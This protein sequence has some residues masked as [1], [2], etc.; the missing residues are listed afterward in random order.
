MLRANHCILTGD[1]ELP[2]PGGQ[3]SSSPTRSSSSATRTGW[4]P[5][6]TSCSRTPKAASAAETRRVRHREAAPARSTTATRHHV[7]R[8]SRP[9]A[10]QFGNQD[11]DVYFY[12]ETIEKL[13][14]AEVPHHARRLH[15]LRAAD[16]ALGGDQRHRGLNLNDYAIATNTVLR[17]KGVP[18]FYLPVIYYPIRGRPARHRVPAADLRHVDAA[19]SGDQQRVLLGDR[20]QPG[21]HVLPRL[22]HAHRAGCGRRIPLRRG[23]AVVRQRPV[24]P[25]RPERD[26]V[27]RQRTDVHAAGATRASRSQAT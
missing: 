10:R 14:H 16:A 9:I 24:L 15:D 13:G 6:A 27:H 4:S 2:L 5:A 17:V 8:R 23:R 26:D 7:A 1:V 25:L 20:T 21:R 11:A 12:G 19:R 18:V 22:V 3:A